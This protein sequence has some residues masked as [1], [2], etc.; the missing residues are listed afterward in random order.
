MKK[1][2][3]L[4]EMDMNVLNIVSIILFI[5]MML[6]TLLIP[7]FSFNNNDIF[8]CFVYM[9]PYL[10]LHEILHSIGYFLHGASWK[11]ITF[12]AH[13]EKGV[14]CCLCKQNVS[15]KCILI[16]LI[17]PLFF[18]GIVTYIISIFIN[19]SVLLFLSILNISGAAGD[20]IMFL[21]FL[22]I[23]DFEYSEFDDPTS[24]GLYS[25]NDLSN[26]KLFGLKYKEA[27]TSLDIKDYN[28]I[29][30][31]TTSIILFIIIILMSLIFL[32]I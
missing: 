14:L 6:I 20:I 4:Y 3:Y 18:I 2:Y 26:L 30:I 23:K 21:N 32:F 31:S 25:S 16:S 10:C 19:S 28:K 1:K 17:Y 27:K 7:N 22:K 5:L 11:N 24:F 13:L 12:G 15:K 8:I 9:I 29:K